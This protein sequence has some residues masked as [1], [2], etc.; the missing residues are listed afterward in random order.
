MRAGGRE[1]AGVKGTDLKEGGVGDVNFEKGRG[2]GGG[3]RAWGRRRTS[4]HVLDAL[5]ANSW[6]NSN[7]QWNHQQS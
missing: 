4:A 3:V 5:E 1:G 7:V 6:T 2:G